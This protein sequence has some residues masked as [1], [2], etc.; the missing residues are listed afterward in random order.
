MSM[1]LDVVIHSFI[2]S[3]ILIFRLSVSCRH[4]TIILLVRGILG[5][6]LAAPRR[7]TI[8]MSRSSS[9]LLQLDLGS[10]MKEKTSASIL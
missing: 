7:N 10:S 2:P 9:S 8:F 4:S 6:H 1:F 5:V 3:F